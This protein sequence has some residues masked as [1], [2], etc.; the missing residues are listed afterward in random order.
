MVYLLLKQRVGG[1][2]ILAVTFS[3]HAAQS[4]HARVSAQV[5]AAM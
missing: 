2:S 5:G 4:L 1:E 3:H